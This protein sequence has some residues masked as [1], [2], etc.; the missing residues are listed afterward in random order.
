MRNN[1]PILLLDENK[2]TG[3]I[4]DTAWAVGLGRFVLS[5]ASW[6]LKCQMIK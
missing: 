4:T 1:W 6:C 5:N 3:E 2:V